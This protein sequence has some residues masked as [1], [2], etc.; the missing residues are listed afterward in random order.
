M[1]LTVEQRD[2]ID[3]VRRA[4]FDVQ[5]RRQFGRPLGSF[6]AFKHQHVDM[7]IAAALAEAVVLDAATRRWTETRPRN[8][9][10][11][12]S[13]GCWH[14]ERRH[15]LQRNPY[16]FTVVSDSRGSTRYITIFDARRGSRY[17]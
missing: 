11:C 12:P 15:L 7:S 10:P 13:H 14:R 8:S 16:R 3:A 5:T 6:Q 17:Y 2:I 9:R 1:D 4:L